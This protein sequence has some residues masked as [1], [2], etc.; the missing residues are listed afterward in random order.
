MARSRSLPLHHEYP[1]Y[2]SNPSLT[3]NSPGYYDTATYLSGGEP[4]YGDDD[5]LNRSFPLRFLDSF[6]R[7]PNRHIIDPIIDREDQDSQDGVF[8]P[9][10]AAIGTANSGLARKLK[11]RHLQMI[12]IGGSI[13]EL[14]HYDATELAMEMRLTPHRYGIVC[15]EW[16][17]TECWWSGIIIDR[18]LAHRDHAVL[19][20]ACSG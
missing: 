17:G 12:A 13:G 7:D 4:W 5:E 15:C 14:G 10:K 1:K 19:H 2:L 16:K 9:H 18:F 20:G 11:G 3:S 8:N 6:K